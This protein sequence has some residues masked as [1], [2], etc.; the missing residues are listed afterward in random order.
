M[1]TC[2]AEMRKSKRPSP[3]AQFVNLRD[4]LPELVGILRADLRKIGERTLAEQIPDLRIY[5]RCCNASPCGRFYCLPRYERRE[6]YRKRL[7]RNIGLELI[8]AKGKIVEIETLLPEV[9][10]VLRQ[11]FPD[12]EDASFRGRPLTRRRDRNP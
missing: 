6:L 5:G 9:D 10:T 11:I 2:W 12:P 8:V 3:P 1:L 7:T 4:V